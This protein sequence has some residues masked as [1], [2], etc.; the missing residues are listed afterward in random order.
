M[1]IDTK[2]VRLE[3]MTDEMYQIYFR[4]YENDPD[5]CLP[6]Q[7]CRPF[8]YNEESVER[9]VQRQRERKRVPLAI[10]YGNEI[11]GEILIK[12]VEPS[13]CATLSVTLKNTGYKDRGI[14]TQAEKLAVAYVFWQMDIPTLYADTVRTNTRSQHVLEKVGFVKIRENAKFCYYRIDRP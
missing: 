11:V 8:V 4:E 10:L 7:E 6:G 2:K 1:D 9:Y 12:D 14:G 3:P 13:V 5:L